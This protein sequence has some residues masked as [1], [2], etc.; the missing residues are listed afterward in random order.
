[1]K[2]KNLIAPIVV[3]L[4]VVGSAAIATVNNPI[5]YTITAGTGLSGGGAL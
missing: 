1:M 4:L 3:G 5:G 2:L